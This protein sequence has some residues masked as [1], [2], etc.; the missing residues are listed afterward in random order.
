MCVTP[1]NEAVESYREHLLT[2]LFEPDADR[3]LAIWIASKR[4]V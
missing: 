1:E 2:A 3:H 4:R